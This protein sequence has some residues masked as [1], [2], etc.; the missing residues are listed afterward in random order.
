MM[1]TVRTTGE[2]ARDQGRDTGGDHDRGEQVPGQQPADRRDDG[3][4]VRRNPAEIA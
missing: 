1:M 2:R 4:A 3:T